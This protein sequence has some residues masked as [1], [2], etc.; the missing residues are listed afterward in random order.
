MS[1]RRRR[2]AE[3]ALARLVASLLLS[4]LSVLPA[5]A[6]DRAELNV[7]GYSRDLR[8]FAF[9][10]FGVHDGSGG[11]YAHIYVVDLKTDSWVDGT[12]FSTDQDGDPDQ[13]APDLPAVRGKTLSLAATMLG[14]LK[15]DV[16][17]STLM[18]LG[19]GVAAADGKTMTAAF[20]SCCG[21][22]DTDASQSLTLSL[23]IFAAKSAIECPV[24][25]AFGY[26]LTATFAD[27]TSREL[28]RDAASLPKSRSC[29]QDYR[30]YGIFAP[31]EQFGPRVAL[32]SSY[33]FDFEGT[34]R[35]FLAVPIDAP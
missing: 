34:S 13:V 10:E 19:D 18:L 6:G 25:E 3:A 29:P 33:P 26:A 5:L 2:A 22:N 9:E 7:L 17:A 31:F 16:P 23:S 21:P 1:W 8:Y 14:D 24:D 30:L 4:L 28:H 32:V 12:P 27:G 15:I 35:R 11:N 20:P